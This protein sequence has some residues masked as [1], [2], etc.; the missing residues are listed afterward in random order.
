MV[1]VEL[2]TPRSVAPVALPL[3]QGEGRLPNIVVVA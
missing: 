2:V 3:P 1:M